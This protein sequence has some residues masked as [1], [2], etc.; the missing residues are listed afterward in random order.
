MIMDIGLFPLMK[1]VYM[2]TDVTVQRQ[3]AGTSEGD[4]E[5]QKV[6]SARSC[7]FLVFPE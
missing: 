4:N 2:A 5:K 6:F 1:M 7:V 3:P